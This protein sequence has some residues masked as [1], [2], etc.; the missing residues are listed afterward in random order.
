MLYNKDIY[1]TYIIIKYIILLFTFIEENIIICFI[2]LI[3]LELSNYY[4]DETKLII[5]FTLLTTN[6]C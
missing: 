2:I 3:D 4:I 6:Y 1:L 5:L